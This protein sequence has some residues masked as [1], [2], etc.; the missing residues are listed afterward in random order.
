ML[1]AV[2]AESVVGLH[3]TRERGASTAQAL[4]AVVPAL[5][6]DGYCAVLLSEMTE[7]DGCRKPW[8]RPCSGGA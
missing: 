2:E 7:A 8:L 1:Q 4:G 3:D 5:S 6:D